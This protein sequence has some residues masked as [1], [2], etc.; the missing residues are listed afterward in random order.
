MIQYQ[1]SIVTVGGMN[2]DINVNSL[3]RDSSNYLR[4]ASKVGRHS[5]CG[6]DAVDAFAK[7]ITT[8]AVVRR[9]VA[10]DLLPVLRYEESAAECPS[11]QGE[12]FSFHFP[13]NIKK[14]GGG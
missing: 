13:I 2:R 10:Y 12:L 1:G 6:Y 14:T 3:G 4:I 8:D 9:R 7:A 11:R 5:K